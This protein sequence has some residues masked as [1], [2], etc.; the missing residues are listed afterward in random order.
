MAEFS[1]DFK[2]LV[3]SRTDIVGLVGESLTLVQAGADFKALCPFHD[4]HNPSMMVYPDRQTFRCWV[5]QEGGDV[6]SWVQKRENVGFR[7]SLEILANR[8]HI[9]IPRRSQ[10]E[11]EQTGR[12]NDVYEALKWAE[13]EYLRFFLHDPQA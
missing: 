12:K 4:D 7:E 11:V 6:F 5:C 10:Y 9:D 8:A 13:G 2:E 1:P 3:R